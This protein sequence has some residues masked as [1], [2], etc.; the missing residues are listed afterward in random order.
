[1]DIYTQLVE[2]K[3]SNST[4]NC[5]SNYK[6]N[7]IILG[8]IYLLFFEPNKI[9]SQSGTKFCN[10]VD[11]YKEYGSPAHILGLQFFNTLNIT[12]FDLLKKISWGEIADYL[13]NE[14]EWLNS[15]SNSVN[16]KKKVITLEIF[17]I[18]LFLLN[19]NKSPLDK[20]SIYTPYDFALY[21]AEKSLI[22]WFTSQIQDKKFN[23]ISDLK[24][25][26]ENMEAKS[27]TKVLSTLQKIRMLDPSVGTGVF[28]IAAAQILLEL[29]TIF[30][31]NIPLYDLKLRIIA[32][33]LYG[34]DI[35]P[36]A[37][38]I[39]KIKLNLW[40]SESSMRI[41]NFQK[42]KFN[43]YIG[44][45]LIGFQYSKDSNLLDYKYDKQSQ[46]Q[47]AI[48]KLKNMHNSV[49]SLEYLASISKSFS[50]NPHFKYFVLEG[51][52]AIWNDQKNKLDEHFKQ[53][54]RFSA[55][56]SLNSNFHVYAVFSEPQEIKNNE[57]TFP[58]QTEWEALSVP[59]KFHWNRIGLSKNKKFD[60]IIGNPPF[61]ALT[62]LP[63]INRKRLEL[64]YPEIYSGNNDL[65]YFFIHR[66][67]AALQ[68]D[69]GILAFILPKYLLKSVYA[70]KIRQEITEKTSIIEIHDCSKVTIFKDVN[71]RNI[72]LF[73]KEGVPSP[74]QSFTFHKYDISSNKI[75]SNTIKIN[76][77][78]LYPEKWIFLD[79]KK[80]NLLKRIYNS[81]NLKLKDVADISKGIETGCDRIFASNKRNYFSVSLGI[82]EHQ[83]KTWIKGKDIKRYRVI[84][85]GREVLYAPSFRRK[86]IESDKKLMSYLKKNKSHLL[87]RS[88]VSEYFTWR[89]GD[90]RKTMNWNSPKIVTPYKSVNNTFAIDFKGSLSSKDVT[91]IIPKNDYSN[92]NNFLLY[93]VG[94]LNS[95][96]ISF[97]AI[98]TFKDLGGLFE[99]YPKQI[100]K[101]PI[102]IIDSKSTR[103]RL[104]CG[105]VSD[106]MHELRDFQQEK[107]QKELNRLFYQIYDLSQEDIK[108]IKDSL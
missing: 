30:Q 57:N 26:L 8:F 69:T 51:D 20:G 16:K 98:S 58:Y 29:I 104:I 50:S 72:I 99:Y 2:K 19:Y 71:V 67:I 45:S 100:Q 13:S 28:L 89:L 5:L 105:L 85:K 90:E 11:I 44:D 52:R 12:D 83:I 6:C 64:S 107:Y 76:Q 63:L 46:A 15:Y 37:V 91:W 27:K 84:Q 77:S 54:F 78:N 65:S 1:M 4:E 93:L 34:I 82:K 80:L 41:P 102:K 43:I 92:L 75:L 62:D 48:Y 103:Y 24:R 61:I 81:S 35:N 55:S 40:L 101:I 68:S 86:E 94:L 88:R 42:Q 108:L 96:V 9:L 56:E 36:V 49:N 106:L 39:A 17:D 31:K 33:N 47:F 14:Y 18:L 79:Q 23:S 97:Y 21:I 73:L 25:I 87:K 32:N 66:S 38:Q 7:E 53:K 10:W 22:K 3:D 59:Q 60:I 95:D 70:K 74:Q